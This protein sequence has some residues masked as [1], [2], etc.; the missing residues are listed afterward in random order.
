MLWLPPNISIL[1]ELQHWPH[2]MALIGTRV[3]QPKT[4]AHWPSA[5]LANAEAHAHW[6]AHAKRP[7]CVA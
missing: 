2:E 1:F 5:R 7:H 4:H 6:R 3:A